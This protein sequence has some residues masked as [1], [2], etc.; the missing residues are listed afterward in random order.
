VAV[1]AHQVD[2]SLKAGISKIFPDFP[3][4]RPVSAENDRF[5]CVIS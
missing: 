3:E 2:R 4:S 5:S 1:N